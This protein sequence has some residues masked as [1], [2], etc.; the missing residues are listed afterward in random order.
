MR[1]INYR[2]F[3]FFA[4]YSRDTSQSLDFFY[5]ARTKNVP[6]K[7][8]SV[9][10]GG[11]KRLFRTWWDENV[12]GPLKMFFFYAGPIKTVRDS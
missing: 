8:K 4:T 9:K 10:M 2:D 6:M 12:K 3:L 1:S 11:R 5:S 7:K